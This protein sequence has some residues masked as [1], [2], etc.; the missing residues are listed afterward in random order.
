MALDES[1]LVNVSVRD[2]K[3]VSRCDFYEI[4]GAVSDTE[5]IKALRAVKG[6]EKYIPS[7]VEK[8]GGA[9]PTELERWEIAHLLCYVFT[10]LESLPAENDFK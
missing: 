5:K 6:L 2:L 10:K 8:Y 4:V 1:Y 7:F 9:P 3:G